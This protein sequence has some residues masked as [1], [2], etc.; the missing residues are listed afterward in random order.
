MLEGLDP[1]GILI[2][3]LFVI[4]VIGLGAII[5]VRAIV[6]HLSSSMEDEEKQ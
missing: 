1:I 6:N 4:S 2:L 3:V 5:T